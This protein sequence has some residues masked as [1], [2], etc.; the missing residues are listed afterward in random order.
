VAL[1]QGLVAHHPHAVV[2]LL[3]GDAHLLQLGGNG[4]QVLGGHVLHGDVAAGGGSGHHVGASLDLVGDDGVG[5]APQLLDA[6][7]LDGVRAGAP[8]VGAHGVQEVGQVHD[9]G[10]SR[11]VLD[12]GEAPGLYG[13]QHDV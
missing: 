11:G 13:G 8:D 3:Y 9:V 2:P 1:A 10:L 4:L 5:A 12:D 6:V 7:D